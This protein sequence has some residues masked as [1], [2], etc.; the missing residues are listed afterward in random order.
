M[1]TQLFSER[2]TAKRSSHTLPQVQRKLH[3][4]NHLR[5]VK[6]IDDMLVKSSRETDHVAQLRVCFSILNK[7]GMKLNPTKC[8][9]GVPSGEFLGYLVTERG[10]EA[11]PKQ[12]SALLDMPSPENTREVQRLTGRIAALNRFISRSTD[13]CLPFYQLLRGNKKFLWD[14]KCEEAFKQLK[15]YLSEPPIL[16]KPVEGEPLYLYIAVSPAA[17]AG[18]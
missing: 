5:R 10:I 7:Y 9:F 17:S 14:E 16:A 1:K 13:K 3:Q 6:D 11:N 8:T 4:L 2:N 12:I 18:S 15:T